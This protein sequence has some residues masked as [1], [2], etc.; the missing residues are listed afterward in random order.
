MLIVLYVIEI[1]SINS[2]TEVIF[3]DISIS[4]QVEGNSNCIGLF[5]T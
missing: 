3:V 2:I 1:N 5:K 4:T